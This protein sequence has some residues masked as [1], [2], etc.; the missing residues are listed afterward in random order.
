MTSKKM[1]GDENQRRARARQ[2]K[3]AG[4]TP[5]AELV[6]KGASK[7]PHRTGQKEPHEERLAAGKRGKQQSP[8]PEPIRPPTPSPAEQWSR[9]ETGQKPTA[10][11]GGTINLS[12]EQGEVYEAVAELEATG[13]PVYLS[14][15]AAATRQPEL[16]ARRIVGDLLDANLLQ[17]VATPDQPDLGFQ[18][19][20]TSKK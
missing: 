15:I 2:A 14:R 3:E 1:E 10:G 16:E 5:S 6:T 7:Q 11:R 19:A 9:R 13:E 20:L 12:E 18:Y 8:D 17:E 4:S